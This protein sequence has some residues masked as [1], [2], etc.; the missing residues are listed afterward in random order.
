MSTHS[1]NF[2]INIIKASSTDQLIL[3]DAAAVAA[4]ADKN[5]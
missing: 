4:D 5:Q 3:N 2:I 1:I